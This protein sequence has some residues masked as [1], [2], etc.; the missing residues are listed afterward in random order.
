MSLRIQLED[1]DWLMLLNAVRS[2][3]AQADPSQLAITM[4]E[5]I[6]RIVPCD[7]A[8]YD[9]VDLINR[10]TMGMCSD[11][12]IDRLWPSVQDAATTHFHQHPILHYFRANPSA[13]PRKISDF[14]P[15]EKFEETG[16]YRDC[17]RHLGV[18]RQLVLRLPGEE[19]MEVGL[20]LNRSGGDF[21]ERDRACLS[22]LRPHL[23]QVYQRRL[24]EMQR[25]ASAQGVLSILEKLPQGWIVL[26]RD[27][28]VTI[29]T[30]RA[31]N[32]LARRFDIANLRQNR[33]PGELQSWLD[34][35]QVPAQ[36]GDIPANPWHIQDTAGRLTLTATR[37][38][39]SGQWM[40][41]IEGDNVADAVQ[42]LQMLGLSYRQAEVLYW[43]AQGKTNAQ[44]AQTLSVSP[45]TVQKHLEHIFTVLQVDTRTMASRKAH[46]VLTAA[47]GW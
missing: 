6:R 30:Q 9:E 38:P 23:Q 27:N 17:Y 29:C 5:V 19:N 12:A 28:R 3:Y 34:D 33:L 37:D 13:G 8:S 41:A 14:V 11:P 21:T 43:V 39:A 32:Q 20:A 35:L 7:Y 4:I 18:R 22:L 16:L 10:T 42:R 46:Q 40:I 1:R 44:V 2:L 36:W 47:E 24:I 31:W 15:S 26:D 25:M 45:R